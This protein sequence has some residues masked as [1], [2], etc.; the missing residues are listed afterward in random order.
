MEIVQ[1]IMAVGGLSGLAVL[2]RVFLDRRQGIASAE[3]AARSDER[4]DRRDAI[5]ERD[6]LLDRLLEEVQ[7][8]RQEA[9]DLRQESREL[10]QCQAEDRKRIE[11]LEESR[12]SLDAHVTTLEGWIWDQKPPPP[13]RRPQAGKSAERSD[14]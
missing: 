12:D 5:A 4:D 9:R 7:G 8:L 1:L 6:G 14:P 11:S 3:R 13:P 2:L 10:R